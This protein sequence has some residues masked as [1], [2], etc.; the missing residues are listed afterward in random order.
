MEPLILDSAK[1]YGLDPRI[2]RT[3]CFIE[4]R[5]RLDA[6]S[7]KGARGPMQFMPDTARRYGLRD[8]HDARAAIDAAAHYLRDLLV[9]FNGR[10]DLALAAYNAGEG[11]VES[12]LTGRPLRLTSGKVINP[13]GLV[14]G[15]LPPY[16]ETQEY[17]NSAIALFSERSVHI[18][19]PAIFPALKDTKGRSSNSRDFSL[20]AWTTNESQ[21]IR[22]NSD[23]N[24][25]FIEVP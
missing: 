24:T 23:T 6:I 16:R 14:T 18:L 5:Y 25:F 12:F 17:V 3:V 15:G 11:T 9:R 4:S 7:P 21:R 8:P 2:L 13:R 22:H 19:K 20:D 10:L 1:R